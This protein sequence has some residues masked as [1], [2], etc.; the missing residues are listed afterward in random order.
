MY[1][2]ESDL[3]AAVYTGNCFNVTVLLTSPQTLLF[4]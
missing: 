3:W 1:T 2:R 4:N